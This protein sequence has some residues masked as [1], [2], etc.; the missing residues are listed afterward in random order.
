MMIS[1]QFSKVTKRTIPIEWNPGID[2]IKER[3]LL[4]VF[5]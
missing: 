5:T 2:Q 4:G 3:V 1:H